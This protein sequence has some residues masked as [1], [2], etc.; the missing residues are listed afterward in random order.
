M[1]K[2]EF[3]LDETIFK[4]LKAKPGMTAALLY[5]PPDYPTFEG[6]SDVKDGKDDFVH[7]FVTSKEEFTERFADAADSIVDGGL[8]WLSYPKSIGKLKYDINRDS[9][10]GLLLPLGWHPVAMVSLDEQWSAMRLKRNEPGVVYEQP[11]NVKMSK[12]I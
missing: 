7:L 12:N 3:Y 2:G 8:F 1:C 5:A 11:K 9:L 4:K 6:F 10:W